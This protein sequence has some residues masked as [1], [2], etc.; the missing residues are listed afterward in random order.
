MV[1]KVTPELV[2]YR[3]SPDKQPKP[4]FMMSTDA[5]VIIGSGSTTCDD[6]ASTGAAALCFDADILRGASNCSGT[7]ANECLASAN[8]F[9]IDGVEV[10]Q[11]VTAE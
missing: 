11:F 3:W 2:F 10:W 4:I 6:D 8:D 9:M 1:F 5:H 7:F